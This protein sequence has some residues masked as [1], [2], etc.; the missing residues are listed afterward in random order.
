[1]RQAKVYN[2]GIFAGILVA[3]D[4]NHFVFN[5]DIAYKGNPVS[6]TMPIKQQHYFFQK[7][8]PFFEGLLPEGM[9]LD[10]LL[11]AEKLDSEDYFSQLLCVGK[12][13]VGSVTVEP[14]E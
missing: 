14:I 13:M 12:D 8:P 2:H 1:M 3:E 4:D 10:A 5:Y 7:F 11:R 9:M 6:L